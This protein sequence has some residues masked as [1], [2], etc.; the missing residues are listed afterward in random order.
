[1]SEAAPPPGELFAAFPSATPADWAAAARASLGGRPLE[2]LAGA[3]ADG[4]PRQPIYGPE[5]EEGLPHLRLRDPAACAPAPGWEIRQRPC[6]ATA[7]ALRAELGELAAW[8]QRVL[9]L[10]VERLAGSELSEL[11][12][13]MNLP[14]VVIELETARPARSARLLGGRADRTLLADWLGSALTDG[15]KWPG[16]AGELAGLWSA[17]LPAHWRAGA[18][19]AHEAGA[20]PAQ[21]LAL[22]LAAWTAGLRELEEAGAPLETALARARHELAADHRVFDTIAK[23]RAARLLAARL[24]EACGLPPRQR[25]IRLEA[26]GT[27]RGWTREEPWNNLLRATLQGFAAVAGGAQA[28]HLP[29]MDEGLEDEGEGARARR[30][31]FNV[32]AI[33]REEAQLARTA[34]PGRGS[35]YL[36]SLGAALAEKAWSLFQQIEGAGGLWAALGRG[37]P[38]GWIR[39][40]AAAEAHT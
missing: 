3:T 32:Q 31:A 30:L 40:S 19:A 36:E 1:M 34:D 29:A 4:L 2:S 5:C 15:R 22:W 25:A 35:W 38:Q 37:L 17:N 23:L 16:A 8:G 10:E 9:P 33:L 6:S 27:Q 28:L 26:R 20:T 11:L 24:L 7:A 14:G 12:A 21:E 39:A 13:G 18:A